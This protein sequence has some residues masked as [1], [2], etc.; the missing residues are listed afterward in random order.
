MYRNSEA[1]TVQQERKIFDVGEEKN[2]KIIKQTLEKHGIS[3]TKFAPKSLW[4][5]HQLISENGYTKTI[6][7]E[8]KSK[9]DKNLHVQIAFGSSIGAYNDFEEMLQDEIKQMLLIKKGKHPLFVSEDE[10]RQFFHH[11][12]NGTSS[13][14]ISTN[15]DKVGTKTKKIFEAL[16]KRNLMPSTILTLELVEKVA[17]EEGFFLTPK[18]ADKIAKEANKLILIE[19]SLLL[20]Q[21][22]GEGKVLRKAKEGISHYGK[23]NGL[24]IEETNRLGKEAEKLSA[25][26]E[27]SV[28]KAIASKIIKDKNENKLQKVKD[29]FGSICNLYGV[30]VTEAGFFVMNRTIKAK[31]NGKLK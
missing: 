7:E 10:V 11:K 18:L 22:V 19:E 23:Q 6:H 30:S 17:E 2:H 15:Y 31:S 29:L 5:W 8:M 1:L 16:R 27:E 28:G 3:K 13:P 14:V 26:I 20:N 25:V 9:L 12:E 21:G 24:S 4:I